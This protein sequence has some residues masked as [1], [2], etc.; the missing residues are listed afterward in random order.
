M[1]LR[2]LEA[3]V[4]LY[5]CVMQCVSEDIYKELQLMCISFCRLFVSFKLHAVSITRR[6]QYMPFPVSRFPPFPLL[7]VS[8][9]HVLHAVSFTRAFHHYHCTRGF[10]YTPFP[11]H[12]HS[13]FLF[14][15]PPPKFH[16]WNSHAHAWL[17]TAILDNGPYIFI[18]R[19]KQIMKCVWSYRNSIFFW[20]I[21]SLYSPYIYLHPIYKR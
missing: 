7:A 16:V 6:F 15:H 14:K 2:L 3:A 19:R 1:V 12:A 10:R 18:F 11:L 17:S 13:A 9:S 21:W 5:V 20:F 8:S 4:K